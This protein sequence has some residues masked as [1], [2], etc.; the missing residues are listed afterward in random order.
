MLGLLIPVKSIFLQKISKRFAPLTIM[1]DKSPII[2]CE[3]QKPSE[4]LDSGRHRPF[5]DS[6]HLGWVSGHSFGRSDVA[7]VIHF[8]DS[9]AAFAHFGK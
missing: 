4:L 9:K 5:L 6:R 8:L 1:P 7:Q 3:P 2:P